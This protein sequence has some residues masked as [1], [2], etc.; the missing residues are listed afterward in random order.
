MRYEWD[1]AKRQQNLRDHH[2]DFVDT[3]KVFAGPT[4]TFEDSRFAYREWRFV[5]LGLL[6][7]IP[8]SIAHTETKDV[9][10][11]ISFRRATTYEASILFEKIADQLPSPPLNERRG[12]SAGARSS[13]GERKTHRSRDRSKRPKGRST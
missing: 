1:E 10:R 9:I 7:D 8:V 2:I 4:F 6:N 13:G 3:P 5:T 11:P 12:R